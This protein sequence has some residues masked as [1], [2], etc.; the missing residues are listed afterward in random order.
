MTSKLIERFHS[1]EPTDAHRWRAINLFGRNVASYK[2][3]LAKSILSLAKI[4]KTSISI[5][6]LAMPYAQNLCEHLKLSTKQTSSKKSTFLDACQNFNQKKISQT[7]LLDI[8]KK[9][10][11]NYVLDAFHIVN[12]KEIGSRFFEDNRKNSKEIILTDELLILASQ[13]VG[14]NLLQETEARWRLVE[15]SWSLG[16]SKNLIQAD[17]DE[18]TLFIDKH[19]QRRKDIT[20]SRAALNGY[21]KS[22]CFYCFKSISIIKDHFNLCDVDHFFPFDLKKKSILNSVDGI[23]NLVLSC[24]DCNRGKLGKF[25]LVPSKKLLE[26]LH[27]RNEYYISSHDPLRETIIYQTGNTEI[28]RRSFLQK[29]FETAKKNLI[30]EWSPKIK[31]IAAF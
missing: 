14:H 2:F 19:Q 17:F 22:K 3:S 7:E 29:N 23:W 4:Q 24:K 13:D 27:Q 20:S 15:T 30:H 26:R 28:I 12:G 25:N 18:D 9:I 21:Q 31:G 6:D 1:I 8:T 10:G 11:F 16:L 5:D